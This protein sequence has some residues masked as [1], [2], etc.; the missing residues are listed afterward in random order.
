MGSYGVKLLF[1]GSDGNDQDGMQN[2][3]LVC[4]LEDRFLMA[5]FI[6]SEVAVNYGRDVDETYRCS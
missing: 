6:D 3:L 4:E 1:N 2:G 5:W